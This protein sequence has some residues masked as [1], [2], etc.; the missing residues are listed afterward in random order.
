MNMQTAANYL[1][2]CYRLLLN[3][4]SRTL[5]FKF[6]KVKTLILSQGTKNPYIMIYIEKM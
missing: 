1:S 6:S 4:L 2:L 3:L 5:D